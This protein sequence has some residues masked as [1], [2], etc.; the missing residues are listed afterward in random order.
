MRQRPSLTGH[1]LVW[2]LGALLAVWACFIAFAYQTGQHEA[3]ELTDGHLAS[4]SALVAAWAHGEPVGSPRMA[5]PAGTLPLKAHDYQRSL[6]VVMWDTAGSLIARSGDAPAP[7]FAAVEEGFSTL[8]LGQPPI[9]WRGFARW[10]GD[11][12]R[13]VL[14]LLSVPEHDALAR[15]IAEQIVEP[16]LWLL[17]VVALAL[18]LAIRRGLRPL[19]DMSHDVHSLDIHKAKP[20]EPPRHTELAEVVEAVNLLV[21]RYH[22]ALTRERDLASEFAHELR[23]PLAALALQARGLRN[24][25]DEGQRAAAIAQVEQQALRAGEV[26]TQL[27]ALARTR[28]AELD[29]AAAPVDVSELARRVVGQFAPQA[30]AGGR[31]LSL[32]AQDPLE[33]MG[34]ETLLELALRN[35]IENSL[36]HTPTGTAV[37]VKVDSR[38]RSVEVCDRWPS[39]HRELSEPARKTALGLGLGLRVVEKVAQIHGARFESGDAPEGAGRRYRILFS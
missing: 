20:L 19:Y 25:G 7:D 15:D 37:E 16:G 31:E 38:Q 26:L 14:V 13:K 11:R 32:A 22:A 4:T 12:S 3:D 23:T 28:R 21:E 8:A 2:T 39:G 10:N 18:G 17:P 33:I 24:P 9:Q 36:S 30:H 6:S 5:V 27:L 34:H 1:L 29:E 35:L